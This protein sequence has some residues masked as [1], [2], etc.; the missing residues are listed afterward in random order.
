MGLN[1]I[2]H[3]YD[4][5][6]PSSYHDYGP[7]LIGLSFGIMA[8]AIAIL[9][10][11]AHRRARTR[12]MVPHYWQHYGKD[13]HEG[14]E[15]SDPDFF[16]D[17][18]PVP[19][20]Q[21]A[22]LQDLMIATCSDPGKAFRLV[23]A[24][25]VENSALWARYRKQMR[26]MRRA[27]GVCQFEG[28]EPLTAKAADELDNE[29]LSMFRQE[30]LHHDVCEVFLWYG[31]R[32]EVALSVIHNGPDF[33][34]I[35]DSGVVG[36]GSGWEF[37]DDVAK[38]D[39]KAEPGTDLYHD[40]YAMLLCRVV[41]GK[42]NLAVDGPKDELRGDGTGTG[43]V[44]YS[45]S[46]STGDDDEAELAGAGAAYSF[47]GV[48]PPPPLPPPAYSPP[49]E[50]SSRSAPKTS[51]A[52]GA[53]RS[54]RGTKTSVSEALATLIGKVRSGSRGSEG[55]PAQSYDSVVV[56]GPEP[57]KMKGYFVS[58]SSQVYPEFAIIYDRCSPD[59]VDTGGDKPN[60]WDQ[61]LAMIGASNFPGY[62][63]H[64]TDRPDA[65]FFDMYPA[66]RFKEVIANLAETT[67]KDKRT[68]DRK[69]PDGSTIPK[70]DPF[71][72]MP[73]GIRVLKAWRVEHGE[74]WRRY[75]NFCQEIGRG[76]PLPCTDLIV[77]SSKELPWAARRRLRGEVNEVYL[78][79]GSSP[80]AVQSIANGGFDLAL[81]G[82]NVG[83]MFGR[84]VYLSECSS[85]ADEYSRD[86][87]GGYFGGC[88]AMLLCRVV[89]G[90]SQVLTEADYEAHH[91]VGPGCDFDSTVGDRE[92][93][94]GTYREFV[95]S[96]Q[97]QV[98]PEY[99]IVYE[100]LYRTGPR[101][102]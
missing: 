87:G 26:R 7:L 27:R 37:S 53:G 74:M 59:D 46:S 19:V 80:A 1:V 54:F 24:L 31:T 93:A 38:A 89:L 67:W 17:A 22:A 2:P 101:L 73:V 32:P 45:S 76:R 56:A 75:H 12:G 5:V 72:D 96:S 102:R 42:Q 6:L 48:T 69:R 14:K 57:E 28:S 40:C 58:H 97:D 44:D 84:G 39:L 23:R 25:R 81:C 18:F 43:G 88:F 47:L 90:E 33:G 64:A 91:R 36:G 49:R 100:R 68:R 62:W 4:P 82:S 9:T 29:A 10:A 11:M 8:L 61:A 86:D 77:R 94:V 21:R 95:V 65:E 99:A 98:Y 83:S 50:S 34:F 92:S 66:M 51:S 41:L 15:T 78:W 70:G 16:D 71:G 63:M 13:L 30:S 35:H 60:Y 3:R 55:N 79:H 20:E 85:K 52:S